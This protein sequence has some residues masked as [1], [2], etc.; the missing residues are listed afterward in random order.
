MRQLRFGEGRY[1][2]Q[3]RT[4]SKQQCWNSD[5][6]SPGSSVTLSA[7]ILGFGVD[8]TSLCEVFV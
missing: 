7:L 5:P 6:D 3:G 1:P 4:A 8:Q 2:A